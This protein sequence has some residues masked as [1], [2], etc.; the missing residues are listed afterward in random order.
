MGAVEASLLDLTNAYAT[1]GRDGLRKN[2]RIFPDEPAGQVRALSPKVCRA[3]SDI[4]SCR[5]RPA[6]GTETMVAQD[7]PWFIWK[8]GTSSGRRDAWAAGHNRRYAIGVWVGRFRGT[9]R[10]AYVG[11][12][13]AEPL[14]A[15]LFN[16]PELRTQIDPPPTTLIAV[17]RP[18]PPPRELNQRLRI[19][20]PTA[21]ETFVCLNGSAIVHTQA[22]RTEGIT[23]FL[24][25]KLTRIAKTR[26]LTLPAGKYELRCVDQAGQSSSVAFAVLGSGL[27]AR[28]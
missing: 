27:S 22:N 17:R 6:S 23:W 26:N 2:V 5:Q 24:N 8:T 4:L 20:E 13:A 12:E 19:T 7:V 15:E 16:S 9:G 10:T 3:I 25:G 28:R 14:L 21:G 1:L 18:L 11:A